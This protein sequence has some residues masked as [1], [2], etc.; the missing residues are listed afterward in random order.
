MAAAPTMCW[1]ETERLVRIFIYA[2][3]EAR[4]QRIREKGYYEEHEIARNIRRMDRE[5]RDYHRYYTGKE[6][7]NVENYD[8]MLNSGSW[9]R[10]A[11]WNVFC[12]TLRSAVCI[13][14]R[15][16]RAV[17]FGGRKGRTPGNPLLQFGL[18]VA[19]ISEA[20]IVGNKE[21]ENNGA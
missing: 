17:F 20:I 4:I 12:P 11:A 7:E 8:M 19:I 21:I 9:V 10:T 6:W 5:R 15:P 18:P 14:H 1:R 16:G 2:D 3:M 13:R